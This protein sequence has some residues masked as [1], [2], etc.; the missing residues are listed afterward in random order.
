MIAPSRVPLSLE[1]DS[2][3]ADL[4]TTQRLLT[5]VSQS[6]PLSR[7]ML[8]SRIEQIQSELS[9]IAS[10][11]TTVANAAILFSG[12]PVVGSRSIQAEFAGKMILRIQDLVS[13]TVASSVTALASRGPVPGVQDTKLQLTGLAFGSFGF[14]FEEK[15]AASPEF[16]DSPMKLALEK[17]FETISAFATGNDRRFRRTIEDLEP[18]VFFTLRDFVSELYA[19][20]AKFRVVED[21]RSIDFNFDQIALAHQ[22]LQQSQITEDEYSAE[23][24][25]IGL[26]PIGRRFEFQINETG[27]ILSGAV[28][29]KLSQDFLERLEREQLLGRSATA[30]LARKT[31][32]HVGSEPIISYSLVDLII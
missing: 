4:E 15:E 1:R 27:E 20:N 19:H 26:I 16:F 22:R 28:G 2:L 32:T 11:P 30:K 25:L 9:D 7:I 5:E 21:S 31:V 10:A 17:T 29:P 14:V 12:D 24:M 18:R 6:D 3:L 8:D 13:K 23:G